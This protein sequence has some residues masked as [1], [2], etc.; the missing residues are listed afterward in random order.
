[1]SSYGEF[2]QQIGSGSSLFGGLASVDFSI[3]RCQAHNW[4]VSEDLPGVIRG[5]FWF[6]LAIWSCP[7]VFWG[8]G[9]PPRH[10]QKVLPVL[11][12]RSSGALQPLTWFFMKF[13]IHWEYW[14]CT[15]KK[16]SSLMC[17]NSIQGKEEELTQHKT[18]AI[19]FTR[20]F[21]QSIGLPYG[22]PMQPVAHP[23]ILAP[24]PSIE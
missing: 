21:F 24:L 16:C 11:Y 15:V 20:L 1:M 10:D 23:A 19:S 9:T 14:K 2:Q 13:G 22:N 17:F 6:I 3:L 7:E 4:R 8:L 5:Y 18:M 12:G